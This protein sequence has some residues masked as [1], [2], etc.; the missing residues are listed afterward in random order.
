M[1]C[2]GLIFKETWH[3]MNVALNEHEMRGHCDYIR[4]IC[5]ECEIMLCSSKHELQCGCRY[6]KR[7][8]MNCND[9]TYINMSCYGVALT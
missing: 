2:T 9:C 7:I 6:I 4:M 8:F 3:A 5:D 1:S